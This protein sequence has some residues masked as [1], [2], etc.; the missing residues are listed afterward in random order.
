MKKD[1]FTLPSA[2][3]LLLA[4][5]VAVAAQDVPSGDAQQDGQQSSPAAS[6]SEALG[7]EAPRLTLEQADRDR[8]PMAD[9]VIEKKITGRLPNGYRS[10]VTAAQREDVYAIQIEYNELIEL[11]KLR[12]ALLEEERNRRVDALLT[13]EQVQ[14]VRQI[15]GVLESEKNQPETV[16]T[17]RRRR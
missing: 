14:N 9:V 6:S 5:S 8:P 10:V 15:R 7:E 1:L 17:P 16:P 4:L 12:I 2:L 13:P 3:F 11:L